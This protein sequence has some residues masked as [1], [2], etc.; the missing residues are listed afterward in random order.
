VPVRAPPTVAVAQQPAA[1]GSAAQAQRPQ[2]QVGTEVILK[3]E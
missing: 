1:A 2:G 3:K